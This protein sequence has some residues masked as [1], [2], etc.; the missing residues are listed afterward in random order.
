MLIIVVVAIIALALSIWAVVKAYH[1]KDPY[2]HET[3]EEG[4]KDDTKRKEDR[5]NNKAW[6]RAKIILIITLSVIMVAMLVFC[7]VFYC[8]EWPEN[9]IDEDFAAT[10]LRSP[11]GQNES[12]K[13]LIRAVASRSSWSNTTIF[14][15]TTAGLYFLT[16]FAF[17]AACGVKIAFSTSG[18]LFLLTMML[19][20]ILTIWLLLSKYRRHLIY[21]NFYPAHKVFGNGT[22][23]NFMK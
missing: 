5:Q 20:L 11:P 18:V 22:H 1:H 10:L 4:D 14:A 19:I 23:T 7:I 21:H 6:R 3:Y 8:H 9:K 12:C 13:K 16:F 2:T 17:L 15:M